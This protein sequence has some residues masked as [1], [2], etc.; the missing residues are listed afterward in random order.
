MMIGMQTYV[1]EA[2]LFRPGFQTHSL[3]TRAR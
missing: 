3:E 2:N 1:R